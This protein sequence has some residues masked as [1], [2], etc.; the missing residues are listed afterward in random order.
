MSRAADSLP[1]QRVSRRTLRVLLALLLCDTPSLAV[2]QS[3]TFS[4]SVGPVFGLPLGAPNLPPG[5]QV[6]LGIEPRRDS[7]RR[8]GRFVVEGVFR[9]DLKHDAEAESRS[10]PIG[11][12]FGGGYDVRL[13]LRERAL[14]QRLGLGV[15][16]YVGWGRESFPGIVLIMPRIG[17][18]VPFPRSAERGGVE[19]ALLYAL[20]G[21]RTLNPRPSIYAVPV[22]FNWR[23]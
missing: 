23:F 21:N 10:D 7:A 17:L 13:Q 4:L 12:M 20:I 11:R 5:L 18:E 6:H 9:T 19:I 15:R 3:S 16:T 14:G 2:A 22:T 1:R 8:S